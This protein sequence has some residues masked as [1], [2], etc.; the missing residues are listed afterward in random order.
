MMRLKNIELYFTHQTGNQRIAK[1]VFCAGEAVD[2]HLGVPRQ[3]RLVLQV[4]NLNGEVV[5]EN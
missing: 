2:L 4:Q 3:Q 5:Y 1:S